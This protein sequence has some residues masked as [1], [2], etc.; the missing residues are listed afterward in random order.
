MRVGRTFRAELRCY[1]RGQL[2]TYSLSSERARDSTGDLIRSDNEPIGLGGRQGGDEA[3]RVGRGR[4]H[5]YTSDRGTENLSAN[6]ELPRRCRRAFRV[7]EERVRRRLTRCVV[8]GEHTEP[9]WKRAR[10]RNHRTSRNLIE[11]PAE[12]ARSRSSFAAKCC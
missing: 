7:G 3:T 11:R 5:A 10:A 9:G 1:S 6:G 12:R 8:G 2:S 4:G